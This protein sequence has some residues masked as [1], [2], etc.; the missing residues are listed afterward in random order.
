MSGAS[1]TP[2]TEI[3]LL[4][5]SKRIRSRKIDDKGFAVRAFTDALQS[6]HC[7]LRCEMVDRL[8]SPFKSQIGAGCAIWNENAKGC[9]QTLF[10]DCGEVPMTLAFKHACIGTLVSA[11]SHNCGKSIRKVS[12]V[13]EYLIDR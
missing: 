11:S 9:G 12:G 6:A 13:M 1:P 3:G 2:L 4:Y 5:N 8:A 7:A 10:A